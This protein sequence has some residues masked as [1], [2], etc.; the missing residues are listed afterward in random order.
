MSKS[1]TSLSFYQFG[2]EKLL[3]FRRESFSPLEKYFLKV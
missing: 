2:K 1:K 3:Q